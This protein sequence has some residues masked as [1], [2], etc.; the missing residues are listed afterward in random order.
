VS[1]WGAWVLSGD[2]DLRDTDSADGAETSPEETLDSDGVGDDSPAGTGPLSGP[3]L[4]LWVGA[5]LFL[6]GGLV[7]LRRLRANTAP[8]RTI[9]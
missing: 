7:L 1:W 8:N 3:A 4:A 2:A 9:R 6:L 5:G